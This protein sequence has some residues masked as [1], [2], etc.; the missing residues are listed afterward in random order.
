MPLEVR[1]LR[2]AQEDV[3]A[4]LGRGL[5][6]LELVLHD[7][8]RVLDDL[9]D[10]SAVA[11]AD[12]TQDTLVDPDDTANEPV[13]LMKAQGKSSRL[14]MAGHHSTAPLTQK[15]PMVLYEQ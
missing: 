8:G 13:A 14:C 9:G 12:L 3:L 15:T 1:D 10:V 4:R 2:A 7:L 11:G 5:L 6:L